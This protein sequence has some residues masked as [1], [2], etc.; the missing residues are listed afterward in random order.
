MTSLT[1]Y[2]N[3]TIQESPLGTSGADWIEVN[4]TYDSFIFTEGGPGVADGDDT[5]TDEE[6]NRAA[7]QLSESVAVVVPEYLLLDVSE[8]ILKEI[9]NAGNQEKRYAFCCYFDGATAS[10]PQLE[11]W[12]NASVNSY[13]DPGLGN[14]V[15]ASSWYKGICTTTDTPAAD[16]VGTPLAGLG[17]SN[18]LPLND[19]N[20][21]LSGAGELYFNLKIVIPGG[22]VT[23]AVHTPIIMCTF[24]TN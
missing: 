14:G 23:P 10:E 16:W 22:Y 15:P 2:I 6:L 17:A 24:T 11:A 18:V 21:A 20:G 13:A 19:G 4:P 12:D 3:N 7:V 5:P 1:L 8:N 9:K